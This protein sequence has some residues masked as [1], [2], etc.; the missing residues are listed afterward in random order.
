MPNLYENFVSSRE[1]D[2]EPTSNPTTP[3]ETSTTPSAS[4]PVKHERPKT[5]HTVYVFGYRYTTH[6]T[7][8][9]LDHCVI[10]LIVLHKCSIT[11]DI[12]KKAF[13]S[14]GNVVNI[15]MEIE[16]KYVHLFN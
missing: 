9:I 11:E 16:K 13:H 1:S 15:S 4:S 7:T 6:L 14:F 8:S 10:C 2:A 5:G 3:K 12:L